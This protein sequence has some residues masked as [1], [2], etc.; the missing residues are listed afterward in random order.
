MDN[1]IYEELLKDAYIMQSDD[2]FAISSTGLLGND[3]FFISSKMGFGSNKAMML[4]GTKIEAE[5]ALNVLIE[6]LD[7]WRQYFDIYNKDELYCKCILKSELKTIIPM[8]KRLGKIDIVPSESFISG[9][10]TYIT[11]AIF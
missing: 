6:D 1:I 8:A 11:T 9:F 10:D 4:F 5:V 7:E 3:I 2:K